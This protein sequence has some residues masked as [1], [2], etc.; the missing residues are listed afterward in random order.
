MSMSYEHSRE[1]KDMS[2]ETAQD[3]ADFLIS[4]PVGTF[5]AFISRIDA[6]TWKLNVTSSYPS[7]L[8]DPYIDTAIERARNIA[9]TP[10]FTFDHS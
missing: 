10:P 4:Q 5:D 7:E 1:M 3:V 2:A 8:A 9:S 6:E